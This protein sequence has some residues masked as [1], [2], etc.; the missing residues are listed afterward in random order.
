MTVR[1]AVPAAVAPTALDVPAPHTIARRSR[2]AAVILGALLVLAVGTALL[3]A[4][5]GSVGVPLAETLRVL[6]GQPTLDPQ[7]GVLLTDIRL[8]R[9]ATA[10]VAGAGLAVAGLVMQTLFSNPLADPYILGV[11]SGAGLGVAVVT[12]GS[13]SAASAFA[14]AVGGSGRLGVVGAAAVGAGAVLA[15]V[16]LLGRW[17]RSV[18]ALL[19]IGVMIGAVAGAGVS[20]LLAF[21]DPARAQKFVLWGLGSVAGTDWPD[22]V[23]L[24]PVVLAGIVLAGT[25]SRS[26]NVLLLGERYA[27]SMGVAVRRVRGLAITATALIAGAVTAF[28]GPIAFLGIAVPHLARLALGSSDHRVLVP[29]CALLGAAVCQLCAVV[30]Q[31]PGQDGVLPLNVTTA[32]IGA[33]VVVAVLLRSRRLS[34]GAVT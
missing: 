28:C 29:G 17:V 6:T 27:E 19:I 2:R 8:P 10:A 11:S 13:G 12:I 22:L 30:A 9:V 21:A 16:L 5:V 14:A 25:L 4:C 24:A 7:M 3:A 20:L 34:A 23:L 18:V 26:L 33:P 1:R 15:L 31:L 32:V